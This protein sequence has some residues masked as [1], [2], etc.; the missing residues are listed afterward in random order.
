MQEQSEAAAQDARDRA[1]EAARQQAAL[2]QSNQ[3]QKAAIEEA[4]AAPAP[5]SAPEIEIRSNVDTARRRR[6]E[7]SPTS[8]VR[9]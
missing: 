9:I 2:V 8:S 3:Q 6:R 5:K 7:F 4:K 1:N